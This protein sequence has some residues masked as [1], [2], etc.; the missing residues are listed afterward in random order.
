MFSMFFGAGNIVFPL[1]VG[2]VAGDM[3]W[4]AI[5][6]LMVGAVIVPFIGLLAMTYF[7][8]DPRFL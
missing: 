1:T 8:G 2:Q 3:A 6:G 7:D 5:V 4:I